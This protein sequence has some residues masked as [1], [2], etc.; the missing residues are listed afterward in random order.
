MFFFFFFGEGGEE[1][2][3]YLIESY[4]IETA[5]IF[6]Y[7][8]RTSNPSIGELAFGHDRHVGLQSLSFVS[9]KGA[10]GWRLGVMD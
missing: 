3:G 8:C 4:F 2:L 5:K 6:E 9:A 10:E 1:A 7:A